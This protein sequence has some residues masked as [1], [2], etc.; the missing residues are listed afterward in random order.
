MIP[1]LT[2]LGF[3]LNLEKLLNYHILLIEIIIR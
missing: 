3:K 2:K 1:Y